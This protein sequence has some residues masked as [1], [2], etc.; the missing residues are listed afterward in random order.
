MKKRYP[1]DKRMHLTY[2]Y[3]FSNDSVYKAVNNSTVQ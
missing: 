2:L 3:L 1:E